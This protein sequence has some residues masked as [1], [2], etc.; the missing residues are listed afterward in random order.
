MFE[1]CLHFVIWCDSLRRWWWRRQLWHQTD[2][3]EEF[4]V[5]PTLQTHART[6]THTRHD[7]HDTQILLTAFQHTSCLDCLGHICHR[8][9]P[10]LQRMD[11]ISSAPTVNTQIAMLAVRCMTKWTVTIWARV[12][13]SAYRVYWISGHSQVYPDTQLIMAVLVH[14]WAKHFGLRIIR[15]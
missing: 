12:R 3:S 2:H 10:W 14:D 4:S 9:H 5:A 13:W 6:N 1:H 15:S 8:C 7:T 11:H